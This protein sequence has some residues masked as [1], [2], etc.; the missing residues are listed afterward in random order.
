MQ[1][2]TVLGLKEN[3]VGDATLSTM[4]KFCLSEGMVQLG[5][6]IVFGK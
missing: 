1:N 5:R 6:R 2:M 3:F 4:I